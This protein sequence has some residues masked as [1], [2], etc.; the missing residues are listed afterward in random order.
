YINHSGPRY[1]MSVVGCEGGAGA[2]NF[3][4][5]EGRTFRTGSLKAMPADCQSPGFVPADPARKPRNTTAKAGDPRHVRPGVPHS[6]QAALFGPH[7]TG[8][9]GQAGWKQL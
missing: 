2:A 3:A 8:V 5:W 4:G 6:E 7:Q 9:P 1:A